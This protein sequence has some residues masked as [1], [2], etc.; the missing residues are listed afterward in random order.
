[1]CVVLCFGAVEHVGPGGP[2]VG[3][4]GMP[5]MGLVESRYLFCADLHGLRKLGARS[6]RM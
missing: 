6:G 3:S 1:M 5:F 4:H 2:A